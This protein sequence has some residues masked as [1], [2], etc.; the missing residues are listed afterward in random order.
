MLTKHTLA[1]VSVLFQPL[2][3]VARI[4]VALLVSQYID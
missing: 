3:V 4:G 1:L 2:Q